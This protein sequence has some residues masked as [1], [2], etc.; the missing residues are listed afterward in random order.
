MYCERNCSEDHYSEFACLTKKID[1][2]PIV[3]NEYS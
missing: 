3:D 1:P 2:L